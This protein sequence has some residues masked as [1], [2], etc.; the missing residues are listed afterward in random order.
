[1]G[2]VLHSSTPTSDLPTFWW[3]LP[4]VCE[5]LEASDDPATPAVHSCRGEPEARRGFRFS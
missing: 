4:H 1:M 5:R 2:G 3:K